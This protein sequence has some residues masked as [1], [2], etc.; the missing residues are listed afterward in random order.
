MSG[1]VFF[2]HHMEELHG[3]LG[4]QPPTP[5][6]S[7]SLQGVVEGEAVVGVSELMSHLRRESSL[8]QASQQNVAE[9]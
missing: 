3:A 6:W 5:T 4:L 8:L 7:Q 1:G 2:P 9:E